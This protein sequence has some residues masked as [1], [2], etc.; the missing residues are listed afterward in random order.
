[1]EL[2]IPYANIMHRFN[3]LVNVGSHGQFDLGLVSGRQEAFLMKSGFSDCGMLSTRSVIDTGSSLGEPA[4]FPDVHKRRHDRGC[5]CSG[6]TILRRNSTDQSCLFRHAVVG[7]GLKCIR[8]FQF[9]WIEQIF[10]WCYRGK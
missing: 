1:M 7:Q 6:H 9:C 4:H 2:V 5:T 10:E 3:D 8:H